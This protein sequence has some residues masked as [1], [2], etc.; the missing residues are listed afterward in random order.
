LSA[1]DGVSLLFLPLPKLQAAVKR[2]TRQARNEDG[3]LN[4]VNPSSQIT[5]IPTTTASAPE[6]QPKPPTTALTTSHKSGTNWGSKVKM[7]DR[8]ASAVLEYCNKYTEVDCAVAPTRAGLRRK[9]RVKTRKIETSADDSADNNSNYGSNFQATPAIPEAWWTDSTFSG[10]GHHLGDHD[11]TETRLEDVKNITTIEI[12]YLM[13][14]P[15]TPLK[16]ASSVPIFEDIIYPS[17]APWIVTNEDVPTWRN[18]N[19]YSQEFSINQVPPSTPYMDS[20]YGW[21]DSGQDSPGPSGSGVEYQWWKLSDQY[22][23]DASP[24]KMPPTPLKRSASAPT[25]DSPL[26]YSTEEF[27]PY[28]AFV[29]LASSDLNPPANFNAMDSNTSNVLE[30]PNTPLKR[31][32]SSGFDYSMWEMVTTGAGEIRGLTATTSSLAVTSPERKLRLNH[33]LNWSTPTT[34]LVTPTLRRKAG[35]RD[36]RAA[37]TYEEYVS[38]S[39]ASGSEDVFMDESSTSV[40]ACGSRH[41]NLNPIIDLDSDSDESMNADEVAWTLNNSTHFSLTHDV[42]WT[43]HGVQT[44]TAPEQP[45]S[46]V[47]DSVSHNDGS[48]QFYSP[49]LRDLGLSSSDGSQLIVHD[50]DTSD[51]EDDSD[52]GSDERVS[53]SAKQCQS[54]H[55]IARWVFPRPDR[56]ASYNEEEF[57]PWK[58]QSSR[59]SSSSSGPR[60]P[61]MATTFDDLESSSVLSPGTPSLAYSSRGASPALDTPGTLTAYSFDS[62]AAN[63]EQNQYLR[64][65]WALR[66]DELQCTGDSSGDE[67]KEDES[68]AIVKPRK[69]AVGKLGSLLRRKLGVLF[70]R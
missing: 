51:E 17:E 14:P 31:S 4:I 11:V 66:E 44:T 59:A 23:Q 22:E 50:Q 37:A 58:T 70:A 8:L 56:V 21:A 15:P 63:W 2:W 12:P 24:L 57:L 13:E 19:Q 48:W 26:P 33:G 47:P 5:T 18:N 20:S 65:L 39:S 42:W 60:R 49:S 53:L 28:A 38:T 27:E 46:Q 9:E 52:S 7:D 3:L 6:T 55:S 36:L 64:W 25:M 34:R 41:Y 61:W 45:R 69:D 62:W 32:D 1:D 10:V 35:V 54:N 30:M 68:E 29:S 67:E 40:P 43:P 16:R